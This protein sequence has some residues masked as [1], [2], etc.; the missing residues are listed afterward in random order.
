MKFNIKM[1]KKKYGPLPI[2]AWAILFAGVIFL[3]WR[4]AKNSAGTQT[5]PMNLG[6]DQVTGSPNA[7]GD[8]STSDIPGNPGAA[9]TTPPLVDSGGL[10]GDFSGGGDL[11][12]SL[13]GGQGD[14][15]AAGAATGTAATLGLT[16]VFGAYWYDSANG[17][18]VKIPGSGG[19]KKGSGK[20][21]SPKGKNNKAGRSKGK[22]KTAAKQ[23]ARIH[24]RAGRNPVANRH[25]TSPRAVV[26]KKSI[27]TPQQKLTQ[28]QRRAIDR[29]HHPQGRPQPIVKPIARKQVRVLPKRPSQIQNRRRP[30]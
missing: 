24:T 9:D 15:T 6:S 22:S 12:G 14:A 23:T 2:W 10:G 7:P 29:A 17:K 5:S 21:V 1:L 18:L 8:I 19:A 28:T 26:K 30:R 11:G 3:L 25:M 4:H 13:D 16:H 20:K 27:P